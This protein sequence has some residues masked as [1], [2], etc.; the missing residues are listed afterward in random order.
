MEVPASRLDRPAVDDTFRPPLMARD[1]LAWAA[2]LRRT[3]AGELVF[4]E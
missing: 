3:L 2:F 4:K 1:F